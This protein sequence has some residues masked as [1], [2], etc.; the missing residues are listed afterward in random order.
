MAERER[1]NWLASLSDGRTFVEKELID[2]GKS[3]YSTVKEIVDKGE[4][5][6]TGFRLQRAGI[7]HT[8]PSASPRAKFPSEVPFTI[9]HRRRA[10]QSERGEEWYANYIVRANGL[11]IML[12][13]CE[14]TGDTWMQIVEDKK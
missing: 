10:A 14:A 2:A 11:K 7:T 4:A 12:W 1:C 9:D 6:L 3:A 13:V 8:A 5:T